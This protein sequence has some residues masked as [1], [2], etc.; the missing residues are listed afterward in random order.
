MV[1]SIGYV[2]AMSSSRVDVVDGVDWLVTAIRAGLE[3]NERDVQMC[4]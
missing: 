1:L 2:L 3:S 4:A